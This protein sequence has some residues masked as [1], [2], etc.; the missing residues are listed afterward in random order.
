LL[1][2]RLKKVSY[3]V[4]KNKLLAIPTGCDTIIMQN[5]SHDVFVDEGTPF[6]KVKQIVSNIR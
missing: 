5:F 6:S 3:L 2:A 4:A 1:L